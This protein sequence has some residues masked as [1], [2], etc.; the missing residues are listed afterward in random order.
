MGNNRC[1]EGSAALLN[2]LQTIDCKQL[3]QHK[4]VMRTPQ[5]SASCRLQL[6]GNTAA[7]HPAR[8]FG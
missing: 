1:T 8:D 5:H 4:E 6:S 7:K 3:A 2:L